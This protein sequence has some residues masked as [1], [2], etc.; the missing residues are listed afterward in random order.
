[1][2]QAS[3]GAWWG[4]GSE[5]CSRMSTAT[6][7]RPLRR[8]RRGPEPA[9][10]ERHAAWRAEADPANLGFR[11]EDVARREGVA[12]PN[13]GMGIATG[14]FSGDGRTDLLITNSRGQLHAAYRSLASAQ[15]DPSFADA[16]PVLA[17]ALGTHSTG[18]GA[19]WADLDLDADLDLVL[20]NGAIPV[21]DLAKN[22]ER[23]QVIENVAKPGGAERFVSVG[24]RVGLEGVPRVNGA[25]SRRPTTTTTEIWTSSSTRSEAD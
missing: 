11:L 7:A 25:A 14:D 22:A 4:T 24:Q 3:N 5:R 9:L 2:Q 15:A 18:W 1:M 21:V 8:E 17:A 23:V 12:D 6:A 10:R 16:R 13:A 20:A 19:S